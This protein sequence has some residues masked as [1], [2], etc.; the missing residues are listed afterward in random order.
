MDSDEVWELL[1]SLCESKGWEFGIKMDTAYECMW[2]CEI[3]ITPKPFAEDR[4]DR[5]Y[6]VFKAAGTDTD[7]LLTTTY[8]E[9]MDWLEELNL[10]K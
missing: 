2:A 5:S 1:Q 9:L 3:R 8:T 6:V 7:S 10:L 4:A